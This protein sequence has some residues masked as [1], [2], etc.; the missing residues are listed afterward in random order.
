[1]RRFPKGAAVFVFRGRVPYTGGMKKDMTAGKNGAGKAVKATKAATGTKK[2]AGR[3]QWD[4]IGLYYESLDDVRFKKDVARGD[5]AVDAFVEKYANDRSWLSDPKVLREAL[6]ASEKLMHSVP[7]APMMYAAYRKE[8]NASDKEAEAIGNKLGELSAKRGNKLMFFDL[9]LAKVSPEKQAE[10]LAA[11]ELASWRYW[12]S[13]LFAQAKHNLSEPEE[14]ILSLLGDVSAGRWMQMT[15]NMLNVRTV[16]K[17]KSAMP[18]NEALGKIS[19][20]PQAAKRRALHTETMLELR[21]L[22]DAAESEINAL[23]TR[24]KITDE[25]R[26]FKEPFDATILGYENERESVLA[27]VETVT[28][29]FDIAQRFYKV[30]AKLLKEKKLVYADRS[31]SVGTAAADIPFTKAAAIVRKAFTKLDPRYGEIF[32]RLVQG[33]Q[34]DAYPRLGKAGGAYCSSG[35]GEPTMVLLNHNDNL[36]SL[37]TLAHEMGHAVHAERAKTQRPA[38]Q[39]HSTVTAET[40]STFFER[41]AFEAVTA[42]LS[43]KEKIIALHDRIQDDVATV[44]RQ[45]ACFNFERDLHARIR[46]R[47]LLPKAEIAALLNT[48]M[49]AYLGPAV[50]MVENDG[51]FFVAWSHIRRFFYVYS[52]AY[53]QLVSRALGERVKQDP[54]FMATVDEQFLRA[55]A[56]ASP[57]DIFAACGLEVRTPTL[58]AEGLTSIERD[59][60]ELEKLAGKG[61]K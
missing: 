4:L 24:K 28:D 59:V 19:S 34:V 16:G 39:G 11:P 31:A 57:E 36:H 46:E 26:G 20:I 12:L 5:R 51:Y 50:K 22:A 56:S 54:A 21:G 15:E 30:K 3:P 14:K 23:I 9:E 7:P 43:D 18:V 2:T 35:V 44:F 25:L 40:A 45:I 1:M 37:L 41:I 38:Y 47:G 53:G 52:Y 48:H 49:S 61:T 17:G 10:F 13:R 58:F 8:L 33:G 6:D 29:R 32:D 27:L 42:S 55:G 60:I